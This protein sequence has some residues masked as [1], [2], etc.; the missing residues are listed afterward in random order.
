MAQPPQ[1]DLAG[2]GDVRAVAGQERQEPLPGPSVS[3]E[4][5]AHV[6]EP[7]ASGEFSPEDRS[8]HEID[9]GAPDAGQD[10]RDSEPP[11]GRE[12]RRATLEDL[13][14]HDLT[15]LPAE[16]RARLEQALSV[17]EMVPPEQ[18]RFTQR[19]VSRATSD[20]LSIPDLATAMTEGGWRG[21]PVHAVVWDNGQ[22]ASLDNRRVTAARMAGLEHM[23][24]AVHAP[25]DRLEDWPQEWDPARRERN[26]L[27]VDIRELPDGTL[28]VGGDE[29]TIRYQRGQVAETW[30]EIA[31]F[32]AAEQRSLLPGELTGADDRPVYAAKPAG[33]VEVALPSADVHHIAEAVA[34]ARPTADRILDDLRGTIDEVTSEL[35]LHSDPL[36]MRGEDHRVKSSESLERKFFTERAPSE[37]A[38]GFLARVND[39]VRFSIRLPDGD[40]YLASLETTLGK[41]QERGYEV[42]DVKNF[43]QE[44]NRYYGM[45]T[46]L[47]DPSGQLFEMQFPTDASWRA[48]KLT[49]EYYEVFRRGDEPIERRV[50]SFLHILRINSELGL[51]RSIPPDIE[52]R[53]PAIDT[54]FATWARKRR[55][56]WDGYVEWLDENNRDFEW[57]AK[58]FGLDSAKLLGKPGDAFRR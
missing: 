19:S 46:T 28:R 4:G 31:L 55:V 20:G 57:I 21:G 36:E 8:D 49:H 9:H 30:G 10:S 26:A 13:G 40:H 7:G 56:V 47:Q 18:V 34:A 6:P 25:S 45:N 3:E 54:S 23:P 32:R 22:I 53:L 29:G 14:Y 15:D 2:P 37:T 48:N 5:V 35:G 51:A 17:T 41:L 44:G 42:V 43:W 33:P 50:H 58:Q 16:E 39:L 11:V 38:A 24:T 52:N 27:G 12:Y 1:R